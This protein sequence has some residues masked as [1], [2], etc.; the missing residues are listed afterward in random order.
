M[1]SI[2]ATLRTLRNLPSV[3]VQFLAVPARKKPDS[4]HQFKVGDRVK[5]MLPLGHIVDATIRAVIE[6][7]DGIKLQVDYGKDQT[8]LVRSSQI[9]TD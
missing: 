6:H 1:M 3:S 4:P 7:T 8:A 9:V 2:A 5:V